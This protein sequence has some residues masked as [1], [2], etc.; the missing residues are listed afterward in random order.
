MGMIFDILSAINN[1]NLQG[2]VSQLESLT[3]GLQAAANSSGISSSQLQPIMSALGGLLRPALQQQQ[4]LGGATQ[5]SDLIGQLAGPNAASAAA[6]FL[7]PELQEQLI[8][9][10]GQKT[11]ISPNTLRQFLPAAVPAIM[12]L[13]NM[14]APKPGTTGITSN[15]LINAFLDSDRDG[16]TD[17]GDVVKF[18]GR[19]LQP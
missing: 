7:T 12:G 2:N 13:L 8:T 4:G 16:D 10:V 15:P 18:A 11:G 1:P 14:G 6:S 19:F 5:L 9:T 17:L 3:N